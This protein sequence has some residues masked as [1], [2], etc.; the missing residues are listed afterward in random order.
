[1]P[2]TPPASGGSF[3]Q[4]GKDLKSV[5]AVDDQTLRFELFGP[6]AFFFEEV[7]AALV[8]EARKLASTLDPPYNALQNLT[9]CRSPGR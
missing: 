7:N 5:T 4:S 2:P 3:I 9:V 6:R 8:V 1:L